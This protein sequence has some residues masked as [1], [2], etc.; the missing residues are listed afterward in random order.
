MGNV[1]PYEGQVLPSNIWL[2]LGSR[3]KGKSREGK[4]PRPS[5]QKRT[6]NQGR[7]EQGTWGRNSR[8]EGHPSKGWEAGLY[9]GAML[10]PQTTLLIQ[11][12]APAGSRAADLA[13]PWG[14][15]SGSGEQQGRTEGWGRL[16]ARRRCSDVNVIINNHNK[17]IRWNIIC[18]APAYQALP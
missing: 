6:Y 7:F 16:P 9:F 11:P 2:E 14:Y 8:R 4:I 1:V 17:A 12:S 18:C 13:R 5:C 3:Y 15:P 10:L